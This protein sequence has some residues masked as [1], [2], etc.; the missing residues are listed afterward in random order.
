LSWSMKEDTYAEDLSLQFLFKSTHRI[1]FPLAETLNCNKN[2]PLGTKI[3]LALP[4]F[5]AHLLL[6]T[7][8]ASHHS[9]EHEIVEVMQSIIQE[10]PHHKQIPCLPYSTYSLLLL[11][12]GNCIYPWFNS[13]IHNALQMEWR[14][15]A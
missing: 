10:L 6:Y 12:K 14:V 2:K 13:C 9:H 11:G 4:R 3:I 1:F 5:R 7:Y 8:S 15:Q